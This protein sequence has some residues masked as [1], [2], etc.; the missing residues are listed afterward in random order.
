M[1]RQN[2]AIFSPQSLSNDYVNAKENICA[3]NIHLRWQ[4]ARTVNVIATAL[5][6]ETPKL[7]CTALNFFLN[8]DTQMADDD[9]EEDKADKMPNEVSVCLM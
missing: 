3:P 2:V 7:A 5:L 1:K 6:A 4:D 9:D 8:I